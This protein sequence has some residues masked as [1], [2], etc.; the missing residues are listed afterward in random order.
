MNKTSILFLFAFL[1]MGFGLIHINAAS[2]YYVQFD[3]SDEDYVD[4]GNMSGFMADTSWTIIEKIKVPKGADNP[5]GWHMFRGKAWRDK[6]GD[7]A[8]RFRNGTFEKNDG[9]PAP[10]I[11]VWLRKGGWNRLEMYNGDKGIYLQG[12]KWY[13]LA[14]VYN[15]TSNEYEL[16]LNGLEV[17]NNTVIGPMDDSGNSN[18]LFFGG[19]DVDRSWHGNL[20]SETDSA[21]AHQAWFQRALTSE[22]IPDY[23]GYVEPNSQDLFFS[24]EI[25]STKINDISGNGRDGVN[26]NSPEYLLMPECFEDSDCSHLNDVCVVGVCNQGICEESTLPDGTNCD[27]GLFCTVND[28][29]LEGICSGEP[30]NCSDNDLPVIETC[31]NNLDSNPLTWDYF[32]GFISVCDEEANIC[33]T[34]EIDLTHTCSVDKCNAECDSENECEKTECDGLDGCYE[35]T[36]RDYDDVENTCQECLCT[37]NGCTDYNEIITDNDGDGYD[38][39]CDNDCNDTNSD[40]NPGEVEIPGNNVDENCDSEIVCNSE[41]DWRN[42]GRF[43]ACVAKEAKKL[44]LQ[45]E[46]TEEEK[47]EIIKDAAQSDVGKNKEIRELIKKRLQKFRTFIRNRVE[48]HNLFHHR[49]NR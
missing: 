36:Y 3:D 49:F 38:T 40:I 18:K 6:T 10:N 30:R 46:I 37:E 20:Y 35:G 25:T 32:R 45:G 39:E 14:V 26:G 28:Q 48:R 21:I 23:D 24:T 7:I 31:T 33:T 11:V 2:D 42:H 44:Y 15:K 27:D 4:F 43:V 19:Q 16:Y 17:D 34:G 13:T 29:C 22:E 8:I 5:N 9:S 47:R 1:L 41:E 12:D